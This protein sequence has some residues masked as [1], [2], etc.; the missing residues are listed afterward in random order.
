MRT[1]LNGGLLA[2]YLIPST[3]NS[4]LLKPLS[5]SRTVILPLI[6]SI[7]AASQ[8]LKR[9]PNITTFGNC[10]EKMEFPDPL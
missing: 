3:T 10:L 2:L 1:Y 9:N 4:Y 6:A 5:P 7:S 8:K